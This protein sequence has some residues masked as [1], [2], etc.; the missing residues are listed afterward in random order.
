M[1]KGSKERADTVWLYLTCPISPRRVRR[2]I[3]AGVKPEHVPERSVMVVLDP[4]CSKF[5]RKHLAAVSSERRNRRA[6][7][8]KQ[9]GDDWVPL[10]SEHANAQG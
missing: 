10:T 3:R 7:F 2:L 1:S 9:V 4:L 6:R 8:Q 5:R